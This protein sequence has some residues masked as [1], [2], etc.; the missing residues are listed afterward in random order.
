MATSS[1]FRTSVC[2][3]TCTWREEFTAPAFFRP[4]ALSMSA[5]NDKLV[6]KGVLHRGGRSR[7]AVV[8][9]TSND[10]VIT[11]EVQH[12]PSLREFDCAIAGATT[13][14]KFRTFTS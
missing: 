4:A 8:T 2:L 13:R 7:R 3:Q 5:Y 6:M 12:C 14:L 1:S 11:T 10:D 9:A